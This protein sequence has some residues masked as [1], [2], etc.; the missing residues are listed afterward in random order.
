MFSKVLVATGRKGALSSVEVINLDGSGQVCE[1]LPDL[2]NGLKG[3]YGQ[4]FNKTTP[5]I[6]GG[7]KVEASEGLCKCYAFVEVGV[8]LR[9]FESIRCA[10]LDVFVSIP[11]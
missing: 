8:N 3:P 2:P 7:G 11:R 5:I 6:C 9:H 1:N 10:M 4:L